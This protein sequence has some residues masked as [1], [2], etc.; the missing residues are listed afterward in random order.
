MP[1]EVFLPDPMQS[2]SI[3]FNFV[4]AD[5]AGPA[6]TIDFNCRLLQYDVNQAHHVAVNTPELTR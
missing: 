4:D 1:K 3:I 6:C 2:M 5:I